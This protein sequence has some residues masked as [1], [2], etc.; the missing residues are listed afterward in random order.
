MSPFRSVAVPVV[1]LV[2][3]C[4]S[5]SQTPPRP[6]AQPEPP[7]A[8]RAAP[9]DTIAAARAR[10]AAEVLATITGRET[11][12]AS[13]V[14]KNIKSL[15]AVPAGRLVAIMNQG[16][17]R[18]L[19]VTCAHCHVVGQWASDEKP[20]KQIARDMIAMA[21]TINT[22][23]LANI[24]NLKGP[25]PVVNCTTCHRGSVKPALNIGG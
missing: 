21:A 14:F 17:G 1:A 4:G 7:P 23:L 20:E 13:Q 24:K 18:S 22:Q 8:V 25:Q 10:M 12:P 3:A 11:E 19:G 15:N 5:P 9:P 2:T 6:G 16:Y